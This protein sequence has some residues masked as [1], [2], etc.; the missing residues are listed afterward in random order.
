[1]PPLH[2]VLLVLTKRPSERR[3][4]IL[5]E[6]I[7][8]NL[9]QRIGMMMILHIEDGENVWLQIDTPLECL[10]VHPYLPKFDSRKDRVETQSRGG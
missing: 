3:D 8:S 4:R 9:Q 7:D 6:E 10:L 2:F 1:M 5:A